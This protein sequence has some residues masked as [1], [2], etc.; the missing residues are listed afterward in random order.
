MSYCSRLK[1]EICQNRQFLL[2][3][4]VSLAFGMLLFSRQFDQDAI[5]LQTEHRDVSRLYS[6]LLYDLVNIKATITSTEQILDERRRLYTVTVDDS[7]DRLSI[8]QFF[9]PHYKRFQCLS[10]ENE[11][12][13][14]YLHGMLC[15]AF[16][17]AANMSDPQKSYQLEFLC[18]QSFTRE[19]LAELL[20]KLS[21]RYSLTKR[22]GTEILYLKSSEAIEDVLTMLGASHSALEIMEV[23]IYKDMRNRVN[24]IINCETANIDKTVS[25]AA[26]QMAAIR[27]LQKSERFFS[28]PKELQDMATLRLENPDMSLSELAATLNPPLS[29]SGANYRL[30]QLCEEAQKL[31]G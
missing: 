16:L 3:H 9:A 4:R 21:L 19:T 11:K 26:V 12:E 7:D 30:K 31:N 14:S 2:H 1:S 10:T 29:R 6:T 24:R 18:Y 28:L 13:I 25:A 23:K 15:G 5:L 22:R 8:I 27:K 20:C 17:S